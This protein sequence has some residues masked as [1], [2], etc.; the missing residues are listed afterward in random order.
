VHHRNLSI[1]AMCRSTHQGDGVGFYFDIVSKAA[2]GPTHYDR[3]LES[4]TKKRKS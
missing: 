2:A 3:A 1:A 4:A